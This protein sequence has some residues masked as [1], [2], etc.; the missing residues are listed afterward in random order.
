MG[1]D[2]AI[3]QSGQAYSTGKIVKHESPHFRW[4]LIQHTSSVA[5]FILHLMPISELN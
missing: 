1:L 3:Y 2:P 5:R 4:A